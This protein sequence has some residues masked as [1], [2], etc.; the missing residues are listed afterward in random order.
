[1]KRVVRALDL[2]DEPGVVEA[3]VAH[4]RAVWPEVERSLRRI[5]VR[6]MDIYLAG[7]RLVMVMDTDDDFD[8]ATAFAGHLAD[9][10]CREWETLMAGFQ[11][12]V[13]GAATGAWWAEMTPVY[14]LE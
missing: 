8:G 14:H 6:A 2:K 3:Y 1:M 5:G 9:P 11:Q 4:H 10:K 12:P 13:P 7:H